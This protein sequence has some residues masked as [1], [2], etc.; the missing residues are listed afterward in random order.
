MEKTLRLIKRRVTRAV[1]P[2]EVPEWPLMPYP[3]VGLVYWRPKGG[4][5]FGDELSRTIVELMLARRGMTPF[6]QVK[7]HRRM[8]AIGSVLH[9][10]EN[11]TVVWGTGRNG[12]IPDRAHFFDRIDVRA[13]RGPRTAEFLKS[14]GFNVEPIYGDPALLLPLLTNGRFEQ[15][16]KHG[17]TFVPNLN[18]YEEGVDFKAG[19]MTVVDPRGSWNACVQKIVASDLIVASSLHGLVIADAF[20][21][22]A[23]YVRFSEREGLFKYQDYYEGTGRADFQF[24]RSIAQALEMGGERPPSFDSA[25]LMG[26]FPYDL[27]EA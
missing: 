18:D 4:T 6:D 17:A 26:A 1:L 24:A 13:V 11:D 20:G 19:N 25:A 12:A 21:I 23:R 14:R 5:N 22:P 2:P 8:L 27:W 7:R 10:A 15:Q 16:K 9:Q 3:T